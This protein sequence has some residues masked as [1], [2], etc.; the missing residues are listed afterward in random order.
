MALSA[1]KYY[2]EVLAGRVLVGSTA[3][4]GVAFPSST[5]TAVTFGSWNTSTTHYAVPLF[6]GG[7]IT[8]GTIALGSLG[9]ASAPAGYQVATGGL[10]TAATAGTP[11]NALLGS[12]K[13]SVMTFIPATATLATGSTGT[14][15]TGHSIES[16]TAGLGI[17]SWNM[18]FDGKIIVMPGQIL[19]VCSSVAQTA[20]ATMSLMWSEVPIAG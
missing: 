8:S 7:G 4:A 15:F 6:F 19:Y 12:G 2:S 9:F 11:K 16:A 13:Q 20:L 18:D 14:L 10:I 1:G 3:A 17:Y 5:G